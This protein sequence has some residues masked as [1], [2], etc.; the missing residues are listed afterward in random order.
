MKKILILNA[1]NSAPEK[2]INGILASRVA[3]K[4]R[5]RPVQLANMN[6]YALPMY[7]V[8]LENSVLPDTVVSFGLLIREYEAFVIVSPE[9]NGLMPACFKN[10]IDWLSRIRKGGESF[11]GEA[12]KPILLLSTSPG[13]NG[14]ATNLKYMAE[15]MPWWGGEVKGMYSVGGFYEKYQDGQFDPETEKALDA[16]LVHFEAQL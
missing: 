8:G 1:S 2:S 10:A 5:H 9:H 14:G 11:F 6:K 12:N 15:L 3:S 13:N 4:I 7:Q 16:L